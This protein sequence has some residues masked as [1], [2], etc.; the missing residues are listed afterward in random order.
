MLFSQSFGI[1]PSRKDD[2]FDPVLSLDTPLFLDPF[3]L[4][5]EEKGVFEGSH[6]EIIRFFD[7]VFQLI[8][9][10]GGNKES[11]R[12]QKVLDILLFPE[13]EELCLGFATKGTKGSGTGRGSSRTIAS[14]L[15]AAIQAGLVEI[16]HFEEI[17]ILHEGIGADRISD[18][19]A[20][21]LRRRLVAYTNA[22]C[23]RHK[24]PVQ[25]FRYQHG[26]YD[27]EQERWRPIKVELPYNSHSN[28]AVLL[29]PRHYLKTL[30]TIN[31]EDFWDYSY[32]NQNEII[33]NEFNYDVSRGVSKRNIV[34]LARRHPELLQAYVGEAEK[35]AAE[36][37]D[38]DRD[39]KGLIQW[40][41][42]SESYV[43]QHPL[44]LPVKSLP[45]FL[46]AINRMVLEYQHFVQENAGWKLLWNDDGRNKSEKAAQLLFLG[47]VKHY[48]RANDIDISPEPNIGRGPVDFK[49]SKGF[50]LR[51]LFELK[52]A[53]NTHFWNGIEKQLPAYL[54]AEQI[55]YGTFVVIIF[56]DRD[57]ERMSEIQ[58]VVAAVNKKAGV[59]MTA[60]LVDARREKPSASKL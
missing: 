11:L 39:D 16:R 50:N 20:G 57:L 40:Y 3:L 5:E 26:Y 54:K 35:R 23:R 42:V 59:R 28:K 19:T 18:I 55:N 17:G 45:G 10:S 31:A 4:Y 41:T 13:V 30:P 46:N 51:A 22:I 12:Y 36:P 14:A 2:W 53:R 52:L 34:E 29:V 32:T 21:I 49:V 27:F 9:K 15:W 24:V 37:Y 25:T 44:T 38:F 48:C 6:R 8:A 33:R 7:S 60:L 56:S 47:I 1:I 43:T 58:T